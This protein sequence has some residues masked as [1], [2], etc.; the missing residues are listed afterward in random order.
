[1]LSNVSSSVSVGSRVGSH[2]L[3]TSNQQEP[4]SQSDSNLGAPPVADV[5]FLVECNANL[6]AYIDTLKQAYVNPT[7]LHF[8]GGPSIDSDYGIDPISTMYS[9]VPFY[10]NDCLPTPPCRC[11][12]PTT[13][14]QKG[15]CHGQADHAC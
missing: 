12:P 1:M 15:E 9:M 8:N 10:A 14:T 4:M 3:A 11:I 13:S 2:T 5:V 6:G 7:L